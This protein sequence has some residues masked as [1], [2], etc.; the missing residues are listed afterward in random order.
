[1]ALQVQACSSFQKQ[2]CKADK[3]KE[4]LDSA[5]PMMFPFCGVSASLSFH[6]QDLQSRM[7]RSSLQYFQNS[8]VQ[9]RLIAL[10]GQKRALS[11]I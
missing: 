9:R 4:D 11:L 1:M 10:Q 7:V 5:L 8:E 3:A 2:R 6:L